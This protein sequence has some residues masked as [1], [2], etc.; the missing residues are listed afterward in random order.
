MKRV[1]ILWVAM[2]IL[3]FAF[4][5]CQNKQE[6]N[7]GVILPLT[8][9][10]AV[11]GQNAK[12]GIELAYSEIEKELASNDIKIRLMFEDSKSDTRTAVTLM[13][14]MVSRER[15]QIVIGDIAS[16]SVLAMAPVAERNQVVLL[17]PGASNPDISKAG[18]FIFRNWQSDALEGEAS[19]NFVFNVL[20]QEEVGILYVNNG[21][22][23]GLM[24]SF[25]SKF[26]DF[27]GRIIANVSFEQDAT[28][29]RTQL[30]TLKNREIRTVYLPGYPKEMALVLKQA[31]ELNYF[32]QFI[33]TQS[34]D[35]PFILDNVG[36]AAEGVIYTIPEPADST[37]MTV[38]NFS[39]NYFKKFN[40]QPGVCS[41][42]GYDAIRI[43]FYAIKNGA[44]SG[45]EF[46]EFFHKIK[47][48]D[49]AAG[50]TTFDENGD[51]VR[52]FVFKTVKDSRF[53]NY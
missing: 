49:G 30:N 21:Y 35:D 29:M 24:S 8:G 39:Q 42:T 23:A 36:D 50:I 17:S 7:V 9:S 47:D 14:K 51:V 12:M 1:K 46:R 11:W 26:Q 48:F 4:W 19:A 10:A 43:V 27:G 5:G 18:S 6:I 38:R 40:K 2:M 45:N 13:Q 52:P 31:Q 33:S 53:V 32:P 20:A 28:N 34:F 16:S 3:P 25:T 44:R 15:V 22:G 37:S 41:N